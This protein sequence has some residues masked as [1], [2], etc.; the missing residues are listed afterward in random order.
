MYWEVCGSERD[1]DPLKHNGYLLHCLLDDEK[2]FH[3]VQ[4]GRV[5]YDSHNE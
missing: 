3:F 2:V 1:Y 4:T 5:F